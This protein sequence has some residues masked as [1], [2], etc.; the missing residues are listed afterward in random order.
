MDEERD[1]NPLDVLFP[2]TE[3]R[4]LN[5][6]GHDEDGNHIAGGKI[7]VFSKKENR[8]VEVK[9]T[10]I[11]IKSR[12]IERQTITVDRI[13]PNPNAILTLSPTQNI[14]N[15]KRYSYAKDKPLAHHDKLLR[16]TEQ[17]NQK[18]DRLWPDFELL[19]VN[20]WKVLT[21]DKYDGTLERENSFKGPFQLPTLQSSKAPRFGKTMAIIGLITQFALQ[22]KKV[23][24]CG[25]TQALSTMFLQE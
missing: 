14:L 10:S 5:V 6:T 15:D 25:S 24:L 23:L 22:G 7:K 1:V 2:D 18:K 17:G 11:R 3:H 13:P 8:E 20:D 12:D 4:E 19:E 16:L 9:M 21:D